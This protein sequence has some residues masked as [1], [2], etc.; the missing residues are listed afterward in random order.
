MPTSLA[1]S[2][3]DSSALPS[4][5]IA[6]RA[7]QKSSQARYRFA[8]L[9]TF[10]PTFGRVMSDLFKIAGPTGEPVP[11]SCWCTVHCRK[12]RHERQ[13]E[14]HQR[15][16]EPAIQR[17]ERHDELP[18]QERHHGRPGRCAHRR[19]ALLSDDK[20]RAIACKTKVVVTQPAIDKFYWVD[21]LVICARSP[22]FRSYAV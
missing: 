8:S 20:P 7:F 13:K 6:S 22:P 11:V 1:I 15:C 18:F 14:G 4:A 3:S 21:A 5:N 2:V 12:H 16:A 19:R 9:P 17:L 10:L